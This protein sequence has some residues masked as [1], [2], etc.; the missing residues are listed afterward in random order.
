MVKVLGPPTSSPRKLI[1]V[2]MVVFL[3]YLV[4]VIIHLLFIP[5][6]TGPII[7]CLGK[8]ILNSVLLLVL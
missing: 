2:L 8:L 4:V 1:V 6:K 7:N 5:T 3:C